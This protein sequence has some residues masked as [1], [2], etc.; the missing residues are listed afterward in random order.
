MNDSLTFEVPATFEM[1]VWLKDDK[2]ELI[3]KATIA[4]PVGKYP[5]K[6]RIK[7]LIKTA[8]NETGMQLCSPHEFGRAYLKERTGQTFAIPGPNEWEEDFNS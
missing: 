4:L 1:E 5:T 3:A 8:I 7:E 6:D 2:Q